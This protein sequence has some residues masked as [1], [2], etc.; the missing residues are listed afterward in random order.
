MMSRKILIAISLLLVLCYFQTHSKVVNKN[1]ESNNQN[2]FSLNIKSNYQSK[3]KEK[4]I[5]HSTCGVKSNEIGYTE[6][7]SNF[8]ILLS[9]FE[10]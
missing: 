10:C 4:S 6:S 7:K 2:H 5:I 3:N 8:I 9:F 1:L